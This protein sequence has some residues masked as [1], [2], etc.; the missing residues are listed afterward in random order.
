MKNDISPGAHGSKRFVEGLEKKIKV[1]DASDREV[2]GFVETFD[3]NNLM[4]YEVQVR[5]SKEWR[6]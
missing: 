6:L 2:E 3:N 4:K 5:E 1:I